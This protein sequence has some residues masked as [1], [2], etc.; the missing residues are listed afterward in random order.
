MAKKSTDNARQASVGGDG[1]EEPDMFVFKFEH[2]QELA[3]LSDDE[4]QRQLL[5]AQQE[6]ARAGITIDLEAKEVVVL[7]S[8]K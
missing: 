6:L 1:D 4:L 7:P 3:G 5:E 8:T 2:E